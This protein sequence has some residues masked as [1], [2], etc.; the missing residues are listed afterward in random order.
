MSK[1]KELRIAKGYSQNQLVSLSG[2]SRSLICKYESGE[3][4]INRAAA[5]TLYKIAQILNCNIEDL[6]ELP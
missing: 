6:L 3:K 4:N 5:E 2:V 1:L